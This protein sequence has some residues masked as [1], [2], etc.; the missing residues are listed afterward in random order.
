METVQEGSDNPY[1]NIIGATHRGQ[2]GCGTLKKIWELFQ[3]DA[4]AQIINDQYD[5]A[6][7]PAWGNKRFRTVK[8][9]NK[10]KIRKG[11]AQEIM[12]E[13]T[14]KRSAEGERPKEKSVGIWPVSRGCELDAL[15]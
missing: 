6:L 12:A 8:Q 5:G 15:R 3:T 10:I 7:I 14:E 11:S 4:V 2:G 9:S 13:R 1:I